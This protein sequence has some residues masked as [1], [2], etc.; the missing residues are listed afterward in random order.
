MNPR[1][2]QLRD[3]D[4]AR[5]MV[6]AASLVL[7]FVEERNFQD[8]LTDKLLQSGVERQLEILGEA[9]AHVSPDTQALWPSIPWR[10]IKS[11]RNLL[12]HEYFRTDYTEVWDVAQRLL[13]ELLP[14]LK[15]LFADLNQRFGPA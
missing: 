6:E 9:A 13:P 7:Q 5:H 2:A 14:T 1:K 10:A 11:F 12:A 4:R 8:L 15:E 3:P